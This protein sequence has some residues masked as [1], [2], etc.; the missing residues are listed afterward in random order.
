[1]S[2]RWDNGAGEDM[3][4]A[5][6][7]WSRLVAPVISEARA[8]QIRHEDRLPPAL[9]VMLSPQPTSP[10]CYKLVLH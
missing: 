7:I 4:R 5:G 9:G 6:E 8:R 1:M 2:E 3:T 10:S